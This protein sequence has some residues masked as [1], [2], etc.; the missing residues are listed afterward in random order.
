MPSTGKTGYSMG[1]G[2][3]VEE[4]VPIMLTHNGSDGSWFADVRVYPETDMILLTVTND[5]RE[6]DQAKAAAA[7]IR[8][9]FQ[10]RYSPF[11]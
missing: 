10:A 4:N 2:V 6:D 3:L 1:W 11:P 5:G 9:G 7:D 8:R